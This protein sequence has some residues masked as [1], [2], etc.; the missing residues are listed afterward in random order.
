[1][2]INMNMDMTLNKNK[3]LRNRAAAASGD[4]IESH[5][6]VGNTFWTYSVLWTWYPHPTP[7]TLIRPSKSSASA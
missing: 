5:A 2:N 4:A 1:M 6:R 3:Q 7:V